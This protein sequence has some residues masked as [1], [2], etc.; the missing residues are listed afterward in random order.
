LLNRRAHVVWREMSIIFLG[1]RDAVRRSTVRYHPLF[2]R[3][4]E[5]IRAN[6]VVLTIRLDD[7]STMKMPRTWT[8][9]GGATGILEPS[10][11]SVFT[12]E[13]VRELIDLVSALRRRV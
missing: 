2:G 12:I 10:R 5:I 3:E 8:N 6:K 7:G 11:D 13:G 9:A 4:M 1:Q